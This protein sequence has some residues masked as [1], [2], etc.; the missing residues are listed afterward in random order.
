MRS[1]ILAVLVI[2][3]ILVSFNVSG[4]FVKEI[5][6]SSTTSFDGN[7][8]YV[9]GSGP[10]NYTTIQGAIDDALDGDTVFVFNGTFIENIVVDKSIQLIGEDNTSTII[11]GVTN[12]HVIKITSPYVDLM[13]FYI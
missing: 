2:I 5:K 11:T 13:N 7:I 9:G 8:L 4:S 10:G 6:E 3:L 1:N 12:E